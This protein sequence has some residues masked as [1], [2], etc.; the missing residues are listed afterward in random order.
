LESDAVVVVLASWQ[1]G[2]QEERKGMVL[3]AGVRKDWVEEVVES[4]KDTVKREEGRGS[5]DQQECKDLNHSQ[6]MVGMV[7][8]LK[9]M[10]RA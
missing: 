6:S 8:Y 9:A 4:C 10:R 1:V 5:A 3:P 7:G 2:V